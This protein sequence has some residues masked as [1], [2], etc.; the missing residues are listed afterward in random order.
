IRRS[1][2]RKVGD[3][4]IKKQEDWEDF[5]ASEAFSQLLFELCTDPNA[6][7]DFIN[8]VVPANLDQIAAEVREQ[9]EKVAAGRAAQDAAKANSS[10]A[11]S[12]GATPADGQ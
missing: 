8:G 11:T 3:R 10:A 12:A 6:A 2:G 4:F 1:Y 9:A 7:G 5:S